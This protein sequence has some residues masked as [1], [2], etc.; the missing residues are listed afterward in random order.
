MKGIELNRA[1][2]LGSFWCA[3]FAALLCVFLI[4]GPQSISYAQDDEAAAK[5]ADAP[6]AAGGEKKE[7]GKSQWRPSSDARPAQA[8]VPSRGPRASGRLMRATCSA[9]G[10]TDRGCSSAE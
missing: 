7:A 10:S 2:G 9:M 5:P 6:A 1:Y 4:G 8:L 3:A